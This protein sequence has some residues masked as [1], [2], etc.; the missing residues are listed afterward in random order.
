LAGPAILRLWDPKNWVDLVAW[1]T[2]L[3]VGVVL[4]CWGARAMESA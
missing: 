1:K 3:A 4:V 2:G